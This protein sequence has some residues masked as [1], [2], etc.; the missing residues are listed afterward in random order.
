MTRTAAGL[1]CVIVAVLATCVIAAAPETGGPRSVVAANDQPDAT[2]RVPPGSPSTAAAEADLPVVCPAIAQDDAKRTNFFGEAELPVGLVVLGKCKTITPTSGGK[3]VFEVQVE[4]VIY[5]SIPGKTVRFTYNW[6]AE[7]GVPLVLALTDSI[8]GDVC[9]LK[10][11]LDAS[12]AKSQEALAS[13]RLDYSV[14]SSASIFIGKE[15]IADGDYLHR[16]EVVRSLYGPELK[17]GQRV[18]VYIGGYIRTSD[19]LPVVRDREM[20]YM[21]GGPSPARK[22]PGASPERAD[23]TAYTLSTRLP[24]DHEPAVIEALKR[25][26]SYPIIE[27]DE[28]GR[29]TRCREVLFRGTTAE[30]ID[31]MGSRSAAAVTL[32]TRRLIH[33][34]DAARKDILSAIDRDLLAT[35]SP[36]PTQFVR[37]QNLIQLVGVIDKGKAGGDL[38]RLADRLIAH[39]AANPPE[40]P[41]LPKRPWA[42]SSPEE[43]QADVNHALA[44][45]LMA[46]PGSEAAHAYG[47]RLITLFETAKGRWKDE[48][49]LALDA[50]KVEDTLDLEA[51]LARAKDAKPARIAPAVPAIGEALAWSHDGRY[52]AAAGRATGHD[53]DGA[54]WKVD[55]WSHVGEFKT[56]GSLAALV[57]SA[58]DRTIHVFGGVGGNGVDWRT[59]KRDEAMP[60]IK[61]WVTAA[62]FS[63]DGSRLLTASY[64]KVR[65]LEMPAGKLLK[66]FDL[67]EHCFCAALSPD[68]KIVARQTAEHELTVEPVAGGPTRKIDVPGV[69]ISEIIFAGDSG[70][71]L[72]AAFDHGTSCSLI[73]Y[74]VSGEPKMSAHGGMTSN[75]CTGLVVSPDARHI[76]VLTQEG[77]TAA[78]SLP[79]LK[80]VKT[81]IEDKGGGTAVSSAAFSPDG[82]RLALGSRNDTVRLFDAATFAP[83]RPAAGHTSGIKEVHFSADGKV[84]RTVG[85]DGSLCTWDA[86]AL[87]MKSRAA[88]PPEY[89][90]LSA[91]ADGKY[92]VCYEAAALKDSFRFYNDQTNSA[93]VIDADTGQVVSRLDLPMGRFRTSIH[94]IDGRYAV[95]ATWTRLSVFDYLEGKIVKETVIDRTDL[96]NGMGSLQ[97]DGKGIYI[98]DGGAMMDTVKARIVTVPSAEA[99]ELGEFR[100]PHFTGHTRGLV[101]GGKFFYVGGPDLYIFDRTTLKLVSEKRFRDPNG[102]E[103]RT[104]RT[105]NPWG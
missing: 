45:L 6:N 70:H 43:G 87:E 30:T 51:A 100:L 102:G 96:G 89:T 2:E 31:L 18:L 3:G 99:K 10:Y 17:K 92:M 105:W 46:M 80:L 56:E 64:N 20:I 59:G 78:F 23:E 103:L 53:P 52:L 34:K 32:G 94:W 66:S 83:I 16:V 77:R 69:E 55:D 44:W 36:G 37:L 47:K 5:G 50:A 74:D 9:E 88:L 13:A 42:Y 29:K 14:L 41:P 58:D 21:V 39:I 63:A 97:E 71:L 101:P 8:Y 35:A 60:E 84:L 11:S 33:D 19:E 86:V 22:L 25:R 15:L 76:I 38:A 79:A 49:Q 75:R 48:V 68:G 1:C 73:T 85:T 82:K 91:R 93:W 62:G 12:E 95:V 98:I 57:F 40:P 4:K 26:D 27:T 28:A 67:P 54:V 7:E 81:L 72:V 61:E 65:V 104:W 24:A 90:V